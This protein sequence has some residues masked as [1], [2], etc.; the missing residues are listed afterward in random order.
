LAWAV[1]ALAL[2]AALGL[3]FI[4]FKAPSDTWAVRS[5]ILPPENGTFVTLGV[6][7]GP[8]VSPDG[9]SVAFIGR[10]AGV[11][12]LWVRDL[13]SFKPRA[14]TGTEDAYGAFW[15]PDS[16]NLA[17]FAQGK[18]KRIAASGG[19]G[20]TLCDVDQARGGSWSR[21]D[22]IIFAKY[23][24][25]IYSV[26][27]AGGTPKQVTHL[28]ATRNHTTHRWPHFLP[29]GNHF[30]YMASA[31]GSLSDENVFSVGSL[32]GKVD[33]VLFQAS[34]PMAYDSG[35]L[36]YIVEKALMARPFD[37][38][39]LEFTGEAVPV[40]EGLQVDSIF[41]NGTFSAAGNGVLLYQTG[42]SLTERKLELVDS[43][44]KTLATL[45]DA[46]LF[47]FEGRISPEGKRIALAIFELN[48]GKSDLWVQDIA[49]GNRT[50]LTV[51]ARRTIGPVWSPDGQRI[52]YTSARSGKPALYL[53]SANGIGVEQKLWE[54]PLGVVPNDWTPDSKS[55]IVQE[56]AARLVKWRL[57]LLSADG[58]G[59]VTPL[60]EV[61]GANVARA[62]L[63]SDGRWMAYECDVSGKV[64][65][66]VSAFPKPAGRLQISQAGGRLPIW[67][68][69]GK[70][71]YY[72]DANGNLVAAE[73][74]ESNGSL[75]MT[76]R[77]ILFPLKFGLNATYDVF[78][79]GKRFLVNTNVTDETPSPLSLVQNWTA[80]LRK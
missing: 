13:D 72:L 6:T 11:M 41:S 57:L 44:G 24:G 26:P 36:L 77:R 74:S 27:A 40:A 1:A 9:R 22:V 56:R 35:H 58:K 29:D 45:S 19:P 8:A 69:D 10:V 79:D 33:R 63:S 34:S 4:H 52:A 66:Y 47:S 64:E 54:P 18:L 73:L 38:N 80:E 50:R 43:G 59:E 48:G 55:V 76:S 25:E 3:A 65:V 75:Q 17:F 21:G 67:R 30:I 16:K 60:L 68:K 5:T 12:Q 32:D 39:K 71:L 78:P 51:D 7:G 20:V 62:R 15:S 14:L 23:P 49:S 37:A 2:L 61:T 70:V 53:I 42:N 46:G 31:V 28:D